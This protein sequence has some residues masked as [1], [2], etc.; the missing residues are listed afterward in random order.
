[1]KSKILIIENEKR[2]SEY[3]GNVLMLSG[4]EVISAEDGR[5]G[6]QLAMREKPDMIICNIKTPVIDG[7]GVLHLLN[8]NKLL[9]NTSFIFLGDKIEWKEIK[10]AMALGADDYLSKPIDYTDLLE[11]V[12]SLINKHAT[13]AQMEKVPEIAIVPPPIRSDLGALTAGRDINLYPKKHR[14]YSEGSYPFALYYVMK[15]RVKEYKKNED[16]K[17]LILGIY[18]EGDFFEFTS[19]MERKAY[20]GT[21]ETLEETELAI[22]PAAEFENIVIQ[23]PYLMRKIISLMTQNINE[24]EHRMINIAY[25]SLRKKVAETLVFLFAKYNG[26]C[27]D[28]P[29]FIDL[30][31]ENLAAIAGVAKESLARTLS[32]FKSESLISLVNNH[33]KI[34][35]LK[36]LEKMNN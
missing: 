30:S 24:K 10:K 6:I 13:V 23:N 2:A 22:I 28:K 14:I 26:D 1:M 12:D 33:I 25:N 36:K 29:S 16:G 9:E 3:I 34:L 21:A 32:E 11:T 27:D 7:Y 31:R 20:R 17:E 8:R 15:G 4:Y 35:D 18:S 19:I 5:S